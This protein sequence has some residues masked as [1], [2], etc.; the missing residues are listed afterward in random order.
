MRKPMLRD[1]AMRVKAKP[2]RHGIDNPASGAK[3]SH[4]SSLGSILRLVPAFALTALLSGCGESGDKP[5]ELLQAPTTPTVEEQ[6][7]GYEATAAMI[8]DKA[9]KLKA[10]AASPLN[11]VESVLT[12]LQKEGK[13][14][15]KQHAVTFHIAFPT[16]KFA[17]QAAARFTASGLTANASPPSGEGKPWMVNATVSGV[18]SSL[19]FQQATTAIN[20]QVEELEGEYDSWSTSKPQG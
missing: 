11:L 6:A 17:R 8:Q 9:E 15:S 7:K 12:T 13:D 5:P 1:A 2:E 16:E 14:I 4:V 18:P 20:A 19:R 10:K 3:L